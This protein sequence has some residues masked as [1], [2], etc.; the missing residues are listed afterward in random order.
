ME[1][2]LRLRC[3]S[4]GGLA[5]GIKRLSTFLVLQ[6][7]AD[8]GSGELGE[9]KRRV[10]DERRSLSLISLKSWQLVGPGRGAAGGVPGE[11][12]SIW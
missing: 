3:G 10:R 5:A 1:S 6:C 8:K 12:L 11:D 7:L 2:V 4:M 9:H